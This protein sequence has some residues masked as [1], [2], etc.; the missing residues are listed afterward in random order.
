M[1]A[2]NSVGKETIQRCPATVPVVCKLGVSL[3]PRD[4]QFFP[5]LNISV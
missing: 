2:Q 4:A 5:A 3:V 1:K